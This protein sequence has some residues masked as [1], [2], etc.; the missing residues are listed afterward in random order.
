[1]PAAA[2]YYNDQPPEMI[3]Y[4][5]LA[6]RRLGD[7]AAATAI[8]QK[9][10]EYGETHLHDAVTMDYFAVS[11][12]DFLVF[13]DDLQRRHRLHCLFMAGLGYLARGEA[14]QARARFATV[15]AEDPAHV[16]AVMHQKTERSF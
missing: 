13:E 15:L 7:H 4:Q 9:L 16:G 2:L 12:P 3:F 10:V 8:A 1:E 6:H 14:A 5:A 11:L